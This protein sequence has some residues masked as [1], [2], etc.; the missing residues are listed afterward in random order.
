MFKL[1]N[2]LTVVLLLMIVVTIV[3][4]MIVKNSETALMTNG[5]VVSNKKVGWGLK[6]GENHEQ[7]DLR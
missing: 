4:A 1:K 5:N 6:R 2:L 3:V 7:P